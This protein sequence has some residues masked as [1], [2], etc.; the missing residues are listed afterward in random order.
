MR[1]K[2]N[3]ILGARR[4]AFIAVFVALTIALNLSP[5]KF[6]APYAPFLIYQ[7]WE[8]PIVAA[9]FF[10]GFLA[11]VFIAFINMLVLLAVFPGMLPTGPL[12]N[13]T[14]IVSMLLGMWL[15]K[16]LTN[17]LKHRAILTAI[18]VLTALGIIF[19]VTIMSF[20]NWAFLRYPPPFGYSCTEEAIR[21]LMPLIAIFN[22]TLAL[23]II[24]LGYVV[25]EAIKRRAKIPILDL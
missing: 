20:V 10:F 25:A 15:G 3:T 21:L 17:N 8:A 13:F 18:L 12:Y 16:R 19:R 9:F 23:Y 24:P 4:T 14:A 1:L 11:G 6:P 5:V 7:V 22:A 2:K